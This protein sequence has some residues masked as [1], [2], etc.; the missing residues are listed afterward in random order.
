MFVSCQSWIAFQYPCICDLK[1]NDYCGYRL[2]YGNISDIYKCPYTL[3]IDTKL[4]AFQY[5]YILKILPDNS[6]LYKYCSVPSSLCDFCFMTRGS[7]SHMFWECHIIQA[8]WRNVTVFLQ[9][10]LS[11]NNELRYKKISFCNDSYPNVNGKDKSVSINFILLLAKHFIFKCKNRT[12][13]PCFNL[14]LVY[15]RE[16]DWKKS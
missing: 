5:K 15:L 14:K 4:R 8:L 1:R 13:T 9:N 11:I 16:E 2:I 12:E 6:F 7:L 3:T 10:K